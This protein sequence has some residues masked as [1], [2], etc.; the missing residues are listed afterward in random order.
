MS[1]TAL[2]R[3]RRRARRP[4]WT[5]RLRRIS[6]ATFA[7]LI[8]AMS[9]RHVFAEASGQTASIDAL[10][11]FGAVET[12][13]RFITT[14]QFVPKTH[15]SNLI[16]G[17]G[18]LIGIVLAGSSFCGWVCPFGALQDAL[19]WLRKTL[20]LPEVKVPAKADRI[21]R[22][23][24]FVTLG[25]ILLM[26]VST[27]KLWFSAFDPYRTI[28][29]LEWLVDF[30]LAEFWPA[31]LIVALV[32]AGSLLIQRFWCRYLCPLGGLMSLLGH[33]SFLRIRRNAAS[34]K[35]CALCNVP[36]PVGIDVANTNN[37]VSTNCIGCLACVQACPRGGTLE[38]QLAPTWL[39]PLKRPVSQAQPAIE[40][41]SQ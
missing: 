16:L 14:G 4:N 25:L 32:V 20:H 2:P 41:V 11:P 10:C 7:A 17:A 18:L 3:A 34:C 23:G 30:N 5:A 9:L 24:R 31:Y 29:G 38:V 35:G 39:D 13:W 22:Y 12:L 19:T 37:A 33:V 27:V 6:Q 26:T 40:E 8:L 28:F 15:P 21:L 36:C 1:A